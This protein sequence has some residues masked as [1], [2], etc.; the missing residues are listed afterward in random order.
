M[1][2]G[3]Y[4]ICK[5]ES[6]HIHTWIKNLKD[7]DFIYILDT[8]SEDNSWEILTE[9]QK[10]M[11]NL[12]IQQKKFGLPFY[13]DVARNEALDYVRT[14]LEEQ[15]VVF[16]FDLDEH[17]EPNFLEEVRKQCKED[18]TEQFIVFDRDGG[19]VWKGHRLFPHLSW[20]YHIHEK[21]MRDDNIP[22]KKQWIFNTFYTHNWD[23]EK[24][25]HYR[26]KL[27]Q[28]VILEPENIHYLTY[29]LTE[30]LKI[31]DNEFMCHQLGHRIKDAIF[32]QKEDEHYLDAEWL[33]FAIKFLPPEDDL[34]VINAL[35]TIQQYDIEYSRCMF[36]ELAHR[37][38]SQNN[39]HKAELY[40]LRALQKEQ[41]KDWIDTGLTDEFLLR[42]MVMFYFYD[43]RNTIS[44]AFY[45]QFCAELNTN[46]L[47]DLNLKACLQ[48]LDNQYSWVL[49]LTN[50]SYIDGIVT[51]IKTLQH[52]ETKY[53][54]SVIVTKDV[55][56]QNIN[57]L[58]GLKSNIFIVDKIK[59]KNVEEIN[60]DQL[61]SL[62]QK[63]FHSALSKFY[64][65]NLIEFS[66][67][68]YLDSDIWVLQNIDDLFNY[69]HGSAL[70]D[71]YGTL[72]V[73]CSGL[74][75]V[76][77]NKTI[78]ND[79]LQY[80]YKRPF[81]EGLIHDHA[82]LQ[83]F[84][85]DYWY[86][87]PECEIPIN[88]N[89]WTTY[90]ESSEKPYDDYYYNQI[91]VKSYHMIDKKPWTKNIQYFLDMYPNCSCYVSL[92]LRYIEVVNY[93]VKQVKDAGFDSPYLKY[94]N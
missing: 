38:K 27:Q 5:N 80:F 55:C 35:E 16:H 53:P 88:Y 39:L 37:Y 94:I 11:P 76:E 61:T 19:C 84:F 87:H 25:R 82:I 34:E 86:T 1:K 4:T 22:T 31:T 64:I 73:F 50:D 85:S 8:G 23:R 41:N 7:A 36:L 40:Y 60:I 77:P 6:K 91:D 72:S 12:H 28:L 47:N 83:E 69:P 3:I 20:R 13:F 24:P 81:S 30:E 15:D 58:L 18:D 9:L 75:V 67:I 59:P 21:I 49:L 51:T 63:G 62:D 10:T 70:R 68:V 71:V 90:Y 56:W 29:L 43:I 93:C 45:A 57:I 65:Y 74:L 17:V 14:V 92:C 26:E 66:K 42:E 33:T 48:N 89:L 52:T 79:L 54:I 46:E 2:I 44:A 32:S 78:Y